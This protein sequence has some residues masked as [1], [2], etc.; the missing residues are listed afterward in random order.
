MQTTFRMNSSES[1]CT[2]NFIASKEKGYKVVFYIQILPLLVLTTLNLA[3]ISHPLLQL[4]SLPLRTFLKFPTSLQLALHTLTL[5]VH[6]L[7]QVH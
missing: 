4:L 7:L 6:N 1:L 5:V 3:F 2:I